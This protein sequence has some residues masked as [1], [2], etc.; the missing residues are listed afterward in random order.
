VWDEISGLPYPSSVQWVQKL[1]T[2][3]NDP[4]F[5]IRET[6][7]RESAYDLIRD[8]TEQALNIAQIE[9]GNFESWNWGS[10]TTTRTHHITG[11]HSLSTFSSYQVQQDGFTGAVN[12]I[13]NRNIA[14]G[15]NLRLSSRYLPGKEKPEVKYMWIGGVTENPFSQF[16]HH[17]LTSWNNKVYTTF[18]WLRDEDTEWISKMIMTP[19]MR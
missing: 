2:N 15:P 11:N 13:K 1:T 10:L 7:Q 16:H 9:Y 17:G 4:I 18:N 19:R 3:P 12:E 6:A 8:A 5:D 14:Q